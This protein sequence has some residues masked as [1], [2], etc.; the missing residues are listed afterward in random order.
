MKKM[1]FTTLA[2]SAVL[3][4]C[5]QGKAPVDHGGYKSKIV[6]GAFND[7]VTSTTLDEAQLK[8]LPK[9]VDLSGDMTPARNQSDRGTCTFFSTMGIIEATIK[10]DLK[11]DVNLSEEFLN[12]TAK[13]YGSYESI[14]GSVITDNIRAMY[15][16]G[17]LLEDDWSYQSS[18]FRKGLPCGDYEASDSTAPKICFSHNRPNEKAL[19]RV[20]SADKIKFY[21]LEKNTTELI[22][23][24]ANDK[25]PVTMSVTVNFNG[26]PS[27]GETSYSEELRQECIKSPA[28]CGGHSIVITG[29]D[30]DKRV[31]MFKNSWGKDWGKNGYGT[32]P[33]N[34]VDKYVSEDFYFAETTGDIQIPEMKNSKVN[35]VKFDVSTSVKENK[36]INVNIDGDIEETSGKMLLISSYLVKKHKNYA[37]EQASDGNSELIRLYN[38]EDKKSAG[39]E[40]IR[41]SAYTIPKEENGIIISPNDGEGLIL[42]SAMLSLP[43]VDKLM[44]SNDYD[45]AIRTTVYVHNDDVGFMVLKR[46]Y[47]P[48][49]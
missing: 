20:I 44:S 3:A 40:Y 47:S 36:S 45:M 11:I 37:K 22:K 23:F 31:F 43:V 18:W 35:L 2:F 19:K 42:S 49:K 38:P 14:E 9:I 16:S 6:L 8:G 25:R 1:F 4:S 21:S 7:M 32:I 5:G 48:I 12:Y 26:W 30:M 27:S 39:D 15:H 10:K 46:I 33:F 24:L 41:T 34:V 29:Y 13:K 17:L 28:D